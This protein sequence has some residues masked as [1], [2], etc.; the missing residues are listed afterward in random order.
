MDITAYKKEIAIPKK[1][2]Q[3]YFSVNNNEERKNYENKD[4][5]NGIQ[6]M[7]KKIFLITEIY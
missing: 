6:S 1:F 7:K 2:Q 4:G 5:M 3:K